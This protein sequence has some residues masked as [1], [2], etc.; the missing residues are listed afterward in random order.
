MKFYVWGCKSLRTEL[1]MPCPP[2]R[3]VSGGSTLLARQ[4]LQ[5]CGMYA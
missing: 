1:L 4:P 3:L 2:C 5:A